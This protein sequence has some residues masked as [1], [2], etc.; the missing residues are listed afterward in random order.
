MLLYR[1]CCTDVVVQMLLYFDDLK[2]CNY[3][4]HIHLF[5]VKMLLDYQ[6]VMRL[7][8]LLDRL[9]LL[10]MAKIVFITQTHEFS[11]KNF[12]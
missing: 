3:I 4:R 11:V 12:E 1:R 10:D 5:F 8:M 9:M 2:R 6:I 7:Q